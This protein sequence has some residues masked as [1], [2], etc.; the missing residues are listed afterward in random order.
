MIFGIKT[1]KDLKNEIIDLEERLYESNHNLV[2]NYDKAESYEKIF[3]RLIFENNTTEIPEGA[4]LLELKDFS[5]IGKT[6]ENI[7][8]TETQ[9]YNA[10]LYC[11][12]DAPYMYL[13]KKLTEG[14]KYF[15]TNFSDGKIQ[16]YLNNN[17]IGIE[18][19]SNNRIRNKLILQLLQE[20]YRFVNGKNLLFF[21]K[22]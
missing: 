6:S 17:G 15:A 1:R 4:M 9:K 10:T 3:N 14:Y 20:I 19:D 2:L 5:L 18:I 21:E 12:D 22:N 8:E 16:F 11:S 13:S 7:E